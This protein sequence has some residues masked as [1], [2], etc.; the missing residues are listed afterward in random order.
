MFRL[1]EMCRQRSEM[2]WICPLVQLHQ[3][4]P[5]LY[6]SKILQANSTFHF[7]QFSNT[8]WKSGSLCRC[9]SSRWFPC[10][11][12]RWAR[13]H[14]GLSLVDLL[15]RGTVLCYL[16][17]A[18]PFEGRE[19]LTNLQLNP[20]NPVLEGIRVGSDDSAD[21]CVLKLVLHL[22]RW[23]EQQGLVG[24]SVKSTVVLQTW[25]TSPMSNV[26][27]PSLKKP[28]ARFLKWVLSCTSSS[29]QATAKTLQVWEIGWI[30]KVIFT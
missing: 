25:R 11:S 17:T 26:P 1:H 5:Y 30:L 28:R 9:P 7:R 20:M 4:L 8:R 23:L 15:G 6:P 12:L 22:K 29:F 2:A 3:A 18:T 19:H 16:L 14:V 21:W 24:A 13:P 27:K 10:C